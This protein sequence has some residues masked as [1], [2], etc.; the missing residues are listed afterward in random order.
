MKAD[1]LQ[2]LVILSRSCP[3]RRHLPMPLALRFPKIG[4]SL[5]H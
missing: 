2:M 1:I 5:S 4:N 3:R